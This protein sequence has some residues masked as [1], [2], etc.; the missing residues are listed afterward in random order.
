MIGC[1]VAIMAYNEEASIGRVLEAL[2]AQETK[3]VSIEEI[4]VVTSGSTDRTAEIVRT[5]TDRDSRLC[6]LEQ[7][8]REGKASAINLLIRSTK[9]EVIVLHN[10]DTV[11]LPNTIESRVSPFADPQVGMTGGRPVPIN[12]PHNFM[13]YGVHLLWNLHHQM[14]L[15]HPKMG[16]LVAFRNIFRQIPY[17]SAVDEASIEPLIIGQGLRLSYIPDAIV[18]NKGPETV[19]DFLKQRR[20]IYAGHLYVRDLIGYKVSTMSGVS[21]ALLFLKGAHLDWRYFVWGPAIA[22]LE[23][24]GRL[25]GAYDYKIWKRKPYA[26]PVVESTKD[27]SHGLEVVSTNTDV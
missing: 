11:S 25:W 10:A 7:A 5:F 6:L 15:G 13:G 17:D 3:M 2:L 23:I 9:R 4:V 20:R 26:W 16:E 18:H 27:L 1:C 12:S 8:K 14:S 24:A 22:L 21:I 19:R